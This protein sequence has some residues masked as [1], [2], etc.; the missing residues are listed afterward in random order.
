M[1]RVVTTDE[2]SAKSAPISAARQC[3]L[4]IILLT[5]SAD[6][7]RL[8]LQC[9]REQGDP[10]RLEMVI[11]VLSGGDAA[12]CAREAEG[13]GAV[14]LI[15]LPGRSIG[16]GEA[17]AVR[18]AQADFVVF[19]QA[20]GFPRAGYVEAIMRVQAQ[21]RW[22]AIGPSIANANP[23][24]LVSR[25]AIL[26]Q[27]GAWHS[28]NS[29]GPMA[30]IP[31]HHSAYDRLALLALGEDLE[32]L[33]DAGSALQT[34]LLERGGELYFEPSAQVEVAAVSRFGWFLLDLFSQ[35]MKFSSM[36]SEPWPL[37]RRALYG[38]G[39]PLIPL[40]RLYR[41]AG[42]VRLHAALRES[43]PALPALL[44]GLVASATG[45]FVGYAAGNLTRSLSA[46]LALRRSRY[47]RSTDRPNEIGGVVP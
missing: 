16:A 46:E 22:V 40:V 3:E 6:S 7:L 42:R 4:S 35:S 10:G 29:P 36:R 13:F 14:R 20:H 44:M 17:Q 12:A 2:R 39:A 45:E 38:I 25:A 41:I 33:L 18:E 43:L 8:V 23:L 15:E 32:Q 28:A 37:A 30:C 26:I 47:V 5:E 11:V 19:A 1:R 27:Y 24:S 34:A 31:G 21:E 9:F